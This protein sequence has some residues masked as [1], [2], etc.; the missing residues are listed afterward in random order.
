MAGTQ[1]LNL[2]VVAMPRRW[3]GDAASEPRLRQAQMDSVDSF[4]L[5]LAL[6]ATIFVL[7]LLIAYMTQ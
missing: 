1:S 5:K 7:A 6:L 4:L 3:S 2:E